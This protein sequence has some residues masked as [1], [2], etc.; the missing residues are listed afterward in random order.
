MASLISGFSRKAN[1][2]IV[3]YQA[4][5]EYYCLLAWTCALQKLH[6]GETG[7]CA[8]TEWGRK[9]WKCEECAFDLSKDTRSRALHGSGTYLFTESPWQHWGAGKVDF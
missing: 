4:L 6:A 3:Q 8:R 9:G 7:P 5:W 1:V 2:I